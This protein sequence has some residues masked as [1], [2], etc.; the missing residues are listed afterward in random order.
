MTASTMYCS[1]DV[2]FDRTSKEVAH[3]L[4]VIQMVHSAFEAAL[5]VDLP[6]CRGERSRSVSRDHQGVGHADQ[7]GDPLDEPKLHAI[8]IPTDQGP[9]LDQSLQQTH[10]SRC[11]RP[12]TLSLAAQQISKS[13]NPGLSLDLQLCVSWSVTPSPLSLR[14][15]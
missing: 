14:R 12:G 10:A 6:V 8:Q 4:M 7:R 1:A 13:S 3:H 5:G 15:Q 9:P 11:R 2:P